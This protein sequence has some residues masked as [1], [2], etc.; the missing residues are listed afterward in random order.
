MQ[1]GPSAYQNALLGI[2]R[3]MQRLEKAAGE[4]ASANADPTAL[5]GP[6]LDLLAGRQQVEASVEA[7]ETI[8]ETLGT[9]LDIKA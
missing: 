3:G 6:I 7:L 9:L 1:I 2:E 4:I 5:T 8:N